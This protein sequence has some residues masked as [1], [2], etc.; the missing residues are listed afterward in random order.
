MKHTQCFLMA[1]IFCSLTA[2]A[3]AQS[4]DT[5]RTKQPDNWEFIQVKKGDIVVAEGYKHNGITEGSWTNY[6][7][8]GLPMDITNYRN[9]RRNGIH[10]EI[11]N[12]GNTQQVETY[13]DNQLDGPKRVYQ[14]GTAFLSEETFY[15]EGKIHGTLNKRYPSGKPQEEATYNM[16]IRDGK[17]SWYYESG[18]K[19]ADYSYKNGIIDGEVTSYY[20]NGKVIEH[21][22][23]KNNQQVGPWKEFYETGT[24]KAEGKYENGVKEGSWKEFNEQGKLVKT[25]KYKNGE[26]K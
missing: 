9:G 17:T 7:D 2:A 24:V 18:E 21:G 5:L 16:G 6:Y 3:N 25:V 13:K 26:I 20:K 19:T 8:S 15:K 12:Q 22:M 23:Y 10:I 11:S 4:L 14:E 1:T